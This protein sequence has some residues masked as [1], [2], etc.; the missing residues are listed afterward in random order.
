M[1]PENPKYE[2]TKGRSDGKV[3]SMGG[4]GMMTLQGEPLH[5]WIL[6]H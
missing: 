2:E 6:H 1:W 5:Q 4:N 3:V